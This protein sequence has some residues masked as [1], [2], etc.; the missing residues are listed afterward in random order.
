MDIFVAFGSRG[1]RSFATCA[2]SKATNPPTVPIGTNV[3]AVAYLGISPGLDP[4]RGALRGLVIRVWPRWGSFRLFRRRLSLGLRDIP[5]QLLLRLLLLSAKIEPRGLIVL[6]MMFVT[7]TWTVVVF[8][9]GSL[10]TQTAILIFPASGLLKVLSGLR[11]WR[12]DASK[13]PH[14]IMRVRI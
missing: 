1:S 9:P 14:H 2:T 13:T 12:P 3:G 5:L 6:W 8:S 10:T 4:I 7:L 11:A